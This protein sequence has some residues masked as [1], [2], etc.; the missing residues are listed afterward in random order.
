[1]AATYNRN[2]AILFSSIKG[3]AGKTSLALMTAVTA[4]VN[5]ELSKQFQAVYYFD[6]DLDGTGAEYLLNIRDQMEKE[7]KLY[8]NR[9]QRIEQERDCKFH[10][11]LPGGKKF[12]AFLL[13]PANRAN[14]KFYDDYLEHRLDTSCLDKIFLD[15]AIQLMTSYVRDEDKESV[16]FLVDCGPGHTEFTTE[17]IK[18]LYKIPRL[19]VK[20]VFATTFDSGHLEKTKA[21]QEDLMRQAE[22]NHCANRALVINDVHR[23][24]ELIR[25]D[26]GPDG[27]DAYCKM[28]RDL[29]AGKLFKD[30]QIYIKEHD[31]HLTYCNAY[32]IRKNFS[33]PDVV[34][35]YRDKALADWLIN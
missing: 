33:D 1:M 13:D 19:A 9:Y 24:Q 22:E 35:A 17:L 4:A 11:D 21:V 6:F 18:R 25:G 2:R 16:L 5:E 31:P 32:R 7:E 34:D 8:F 10:I 30:S 14:G 23:V 3:G 15:N 12:Y 28:V 20:E 27:L 29:L 26:R